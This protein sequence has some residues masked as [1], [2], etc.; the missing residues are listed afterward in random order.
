MT[1][2]DDPQYDASEA[3]SAVTTWLLPEYKSREDELIHLV[4]GAAFVGVTRSAVTN[5]VK[6]I[7]TSPRSLSSQA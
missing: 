2:P 7:Q 6:P 5:W 1:T 4:A 3:A